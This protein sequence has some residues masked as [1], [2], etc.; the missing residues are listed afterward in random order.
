MNQTILAPRSEPGR[1]LRFAVV[2][3]SGTVIDLV[4]LTILK[5]GFGLPTVLAN[6]LSYSAG[7]I[8][9]FA[10]NRAWTFRDARTKSLAAQFVQFAIVSGIGLLLNDLIVVTLEKPFGNLPG[11]MHAGYIPA[12][13]AATGLVLI[14]NFMANRLWTFNDSRN[15]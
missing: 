12:K 2:G 10:L 14:W 7:I 8:N 9:N 13:I 6:T 3:A 4:L 1:L 5:T 11:N 15:G